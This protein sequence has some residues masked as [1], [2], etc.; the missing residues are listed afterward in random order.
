MFTS[1]IFTIVVHFFRHYYYY[2]Y[3]WRQTIVRPPEFDW[4]HTSSWL[5]SM[6]NNNL[7]RS[8]IGPD[9]SRDLYTAPSSMLTCHWSKAGHVIILPFIFAEF[10]R[11]RA[12]WLDSREHQKYLDFHSPNVYKSHTQLSPE[13]S[14]AVLYL[15]ANLCT[16]HISLCCTMN[17]KYE[18][19]ELE[20]KRKCFLPLGRERQIGNRKIYVLDKLL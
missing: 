18:C 12:S 9:R 19:C 13:H 6:S 15:P 4:D 11:V 3:S 8:L 7:R 2:Y 16:I 20:Q 5:L 1:L 14:R 17:L 10:V